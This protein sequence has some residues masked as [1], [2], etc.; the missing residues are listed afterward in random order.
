VVSSLAAG[1]YT[2][3]VHATNAAGNG[4]NASASATVTAATPVIAWTPTSPIT[5]GTPLGA[6][7]LNAT[8]SYNGNP[9]AGTFTYT[10]TLGEVLP[11]GN[12]QTLSLTFTPT[13]TASYA[14]ATEAATIDVNPKPLQVTGTSAQNKP[15]DGTATATL[16]GGTLVGVIAADAGSVTLAQAGAFAQ[17]N[18][19]M[20][21]A[22]TANDSIGGSAAGNYTLTQPAGLSANITPATLTYTA[23][24]TTVPYGTT[25]SG[26]GGTLSGF[27]AGE[28]QAT[29]TTGT[30]P[31][32]PR[33]TRRAWSVNI[34]SPAAA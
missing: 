2:F 7:Q 15:Y 18:V 31:S 29:A 4:P 16:S 24:P 21:I 12:G 6:T 17:A 30:W 20:S 3:T 14:S 10:P 33:R 8:A 22:I 19:G 5:Y 28:T 25:P 13:D 23:T 11:A 32:R 27:I 34:R 1:S 9:V 26:L